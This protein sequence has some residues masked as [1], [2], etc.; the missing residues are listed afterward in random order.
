M[1]APDP[2]SGRPLRA[3]Q[4]IDSLGRAGAEQSLAALAPH[5]VAEGV[6]LHVA[7]LVERD[8]LRADIERAGVPVVSLAEP[9][10][11]RRRWLAR[12]RELVRELRPDVVHTALFEADLAGRRAAHELGVPCVSSLVNT[13]YGPRE[14]GGQTNVRWIKLRG[15]QAVD[16]LTARRVA[17]F[18][19][20]T[21][22]VAA[23]M[24]RRLLV[25]RARIEVI[26]RGRDAAVLGRRSPQRIADTRQRLDIAADTPLILA[27]GRHE[28][29]KGLDVLL[30]A[31]PRVRAQVPGVRV[32]IAGREGRE[33][34]DLHARTQAA[35]LADAVTFLG[36]RDDVADLLCAA[37]V[38]AFPSL[39]EGAGGTLLEAMALDCPIVSSRLPTLLE[40][41]DAT[42]AELVAPGRP[43]DLA[44]RLVASLTDRT[45]AR[46]RA[47][48]ARARFEQSYTI[49]VSARRMAGLYARVAG[50]TSGDR[51]GQA[52]G[53]ARGRAARPWAP[54]RRPHASHGAA[55]AAPT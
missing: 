34:A 50:A 12:T 19:A 39:R 11:G 52:T 41:I 37:D 44:S 5:L 54:P 7:Y 33:T 13:T 40:T 51:D 23:V 29:Q 8:G 20:V 26:P 14:A 36:M 22:H 21:D 48:A 38:F 55:R 27:V 30:A 46:G 6:D 10:A 32:L 47:E 16:V 45:A 43:D 2:A 35:G 28:A 17:R 49:E 15:A 42:T 4:I 3:L 18:H 31:L 24:S 25:P 1:A 9:G 53:P